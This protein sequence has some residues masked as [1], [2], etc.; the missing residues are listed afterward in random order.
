[1][2]VCKCNKVLLPNGGIRWKTNTLA[3][4]PIIIHGTC[5]WCSQSYIFFSRPVIHL[6]FLM[7]FDTQSHNMGRGSL[8]PVNRWEAHTRTDSET[9]EE[10]E[11]PADRNEGSSGNRSNNMQGCKE[12]PESKTP[13]A[14]F[15]SSSHSPASAHALGERGRIR[16]CLFGAT[17]SRRMLLISSFFFLLQRDEFFFFLQ[18]SASQDHN[19]RP[20]LAFVLCHALDAMCGYIL[21]EIIQMGFPSTLEFRNFAHPLSSNA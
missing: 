21:T 4:N 7:N 3:Q 2:S 18:V 5:L 13:D 8:T 15:P 16:Q 17:V 14:G 19:Q 6:L 10:P 20:C 1:M 11:K 12:M 9:I